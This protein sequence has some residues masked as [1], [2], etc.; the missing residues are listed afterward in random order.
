MVHIPK[1]AGVS[2][3]RYFNEGTEG[4]HITWD[5]YEVSFPDEYKAF[6]K[7]SVARNTWDWYTSLF[8]YFFYQEKGEHYKDDFSIREAR[9]ESYRK[10][11]HNFDDSIEKN[12]RLRKRGG[13]AIMYK[14][15]YEYVYDENNT[16]MVDKLFHFDEID[17]CWAWLMSEIGEKDDMPEVNRIPSGHHYSAYYNDE[18]A[19]KVGKLYKKDIKLFNFKF[20]RKEEFNENLAFGRV[21]GENN[22]ETIKLRG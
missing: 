8:R 14:P 11:V 20:E 19:E 13:T 10:G 16:L 2:I 17:K 5:Q 18:M 3:Q 21:D 9:Q 12:V 4:G 1:N 15:Q 22:Y 6:I 7:F